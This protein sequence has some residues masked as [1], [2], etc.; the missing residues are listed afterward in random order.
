MDYITK[1][2]L[3]PYIDKRGDHWGVITGIIGYA[4]EDKIGDKVLISTKEEREENDRL[5]EIRLKQAQQIIEDYKQ[6]QELKQKKLEEKERNEHLRRILCDGDYQD[7]VINTA[8]QNEWIK[9]AP[10][11]NDLL[12]FEEFK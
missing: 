10:V 11:E 8:V 6:E 3:R 1:V 7:E 2:W 9:L 5:F 12:P 4:G